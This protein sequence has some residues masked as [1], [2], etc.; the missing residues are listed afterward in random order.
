MDVDA[1]STETAPPVDPELAPRLN[2]MLAAVPA[3][4]K[5]DLVRLLRA[6]PPLT[7]AAVLGGR[8]DISVRDALIPAMADR[9]AIELSIFTPA[10]HDAQESG[11]VIVYVH[12]GGMVAGNRFTGV[13]VTFPWLLELGLTVVS[14]EY[15]RP[16]EFRYP[17]A[18][19]DVLATIDFVQRDAE[20]GIDP[21]RVVVA[22]SSGGAACACSAV[23]AHAATDSV[24]LKGLVLMGPML[25]DRDQTTSARQYADP[26]RAL[27][28]RALNRQAWQ[29]YLGDASGAPEA[30]PARHPDPGRLPAS[31]I[32]C[33]SAE[34]MRDESVALASA[35]W[36]AGGDC[37]L[38]VW[39]GGFHGFDYLLPETALSQDCTR[40]RIS[41]LRRLLQY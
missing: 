39:N 37:A 41:W 38:H 33:G 40:T 2:A 6:A 8:G 11:P 13:T 29:A 1:G 31:L 7:A 14:A 22:A 16:P 34:L 36:A 30:V 26:T 9:P 20:L 19:D 18:P 5:S 10:G 12:G 21:A 28:D 3:E 17:A 27:W 32:D 24:P 15:R 25:D 35:I 23:F 4:A